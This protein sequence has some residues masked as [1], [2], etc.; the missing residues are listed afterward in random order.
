MEKV[1]TPDASTIEDLASLLKIEPRQTCKMVFMVGSFIS[2]KTGEEEDKLV[3]AA[4]RGDL[5]V[6]ESK[7]SNAI[8]CSSPRPSR[9]NR[10]IWHGSRLR[11]PNRSKEGI[12]TVR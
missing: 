4:I 2:D 1:A 6:E 7:L 12:C 3:V 9:G 11:F 5:D 10:G 8:Q